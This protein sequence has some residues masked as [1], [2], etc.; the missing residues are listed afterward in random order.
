MNMFVW[1]VALTFLYFVALILSIFYLGLTPMASWNEFGDFLAGAFSPVAFLW[2]VLGYLQQQKE[3][4]QNTRALELQADELKNSVD[5]Y[6]EMVRVANEQLEAD[7]QVIARQ[8]EMV[9]MENKP[10]ICLKYTRWASRAGL[11]YYFKWAFVNNGREARNIHVNFSP[12]FGEWDKF[13][14]NKFPEG[15]VLLPEIKLLKENIPSDI[16]VTLSFENIFGREYMKVYE[17]TVNEDYHYIIK[18]EKDV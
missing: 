16:I 15:D 17:L 4:Q 11:D 6:K 9:E 2:L 1:G 12:K 5:Q 14:W 7:R 10:D 13:S 18:F 3:L 8:Y